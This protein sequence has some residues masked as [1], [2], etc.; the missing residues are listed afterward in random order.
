MPGLDREPTPLRRRSPAGPS[1]GRSPG[2]DSAS[3]TDCTAPRVAPGELRILRGACPASSN[4]AA[5][6]CSSSAVGSLCSNATLSS[7]AASPPGADD[8]GAP[9]VP[10]AETSRS[11]GPKPQTGRESG[12]MRVVI[13]VQP[14]ADEIVGRHPGPREHVAHPRERRRSS[15]RAPPRRMTPPP[16]RRTAGEARPGPP[17]PRP[18]PATVTEPPGASASVTRAQSESS[19]RSRS[20]ASPS[21]G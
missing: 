20:P 5:R 7:R 1:A 14:V 13:E 9:P 2:D 10:A 15:D 16:R 3:S 4:A 8:V 17:A 19:R 21:T 11:G 6:A 12:P 18:T